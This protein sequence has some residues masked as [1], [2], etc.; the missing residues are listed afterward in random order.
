MTEAR[1]PP[2]NPGQPTSRVGRLKQFVR[3]FLDLQVATVSAD[4]KPF[5]QSR[6]GSLLEVGPGDQPYRHYVPEGVSYTGLEWEYA[7]SEFAMQAPPDVVYYQ[8]G[9]FPFDDNQYDSVFHTEVLEHVVDYRI[10]LSECCRVLKPGGQILFSVP[11][12]A[13]FHFIPHDYW[14]FTPT[15]LQTI[16]GDAGFSNILAKPRGSDITIACYK[17]VAVFYRWAYGGLI[18]KLVF[19]LFAPS[20]AILL[21]I[22]HASLRFTLGSTDD[23]L[24][25]TVSATKP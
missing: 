14:R 19:A 21:L 20:I 23:C 8:G 25:Y 10:F 15:G 16:M 2:A 24:G 22:A 3:H 6:T 1:K 13:R 9:R 7:R 5:L 11:F 12:Q 18:G 4:V 17:T